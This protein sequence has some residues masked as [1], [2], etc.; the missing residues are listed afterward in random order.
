MEN[1]GT[2]DTDHTEHDCRHLYHM[3]IMCI[4][5][6]VHPLEPPLVTGEGSKMDESGSGFAWRPGKDKLG[7]PGGLLSA[8]GCPNLVFPCFLIFMSC[9]G[10]WSTELTHCPNSCLLENAPSLLLQVYTRYLALEYSLRVPRQGAEGT[11]ANVSSIVCLQAY[12]ECLQVV[13]THVQ[14]FRLMN[15]ENSREI[16]RH[17]IGISITRFHSSSKFDRMAERLPSC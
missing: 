1:H 14:R 16:Q 13:S 8:F 15:I 7:A 10:A 6:Q 4:S 11:P 2:S 17:T 12:S 3:Y 5:V 9:I